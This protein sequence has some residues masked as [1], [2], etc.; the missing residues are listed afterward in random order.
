M[1]R[2][3]AVREGATEWRHCVLVSNGRV[4]EIR[5]TQCK[6]L[7]CKCEKWVVQHVPRG[8]TG[9]ASAMQACNFTSDCIQK[10]ADAGTS[11]K[12]GP[13]ARS[14]EGPWAFKASQALKNAITVGECVRDLSL[15]LS[16]CRLRKW[17]QTM[18]DHTLLNHIDKRTAK[19][20]TI[21]WF[22]AS[23]RL[24]GSCAMP[25]GACFVPCTHLHSPCDMA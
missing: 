24:T 9:R 13:G 19:Q 16:W 2:W 10:M 17:P 25:R 3:R 15:Q 8:R 7:G 20:S 23:N 12:R 5:N 6:K 22:G 21:A 18:T 4:V 1:W 14:G 11:S